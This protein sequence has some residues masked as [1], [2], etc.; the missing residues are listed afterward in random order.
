MDFRVADDGDLVIESGDFAIA[1]DSRLQETRA[2]LVTSPGNWKQF[3]LVG[4]GEDAFIEGPITAE[5]RRTIALQMQADGKRLR[6]LTLTPVGGL[7]VDV[8]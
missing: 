6:G 8:E 4:V 3:P 2:I 7:K 5:L 1:D